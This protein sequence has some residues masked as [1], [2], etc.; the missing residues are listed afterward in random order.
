MEN[1]EG[2]AHRVFGC[3]DGDIIL[4]HDING[5]ASSYADAYLP[6]LVNKRGFLLVTVE[7]L[8]VLRGVELLPAQVYT[9][10]PPGQ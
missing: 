5:L 3:R 1:I 6:R 7:D 9:N 2:V 8:C 10:C 4:C